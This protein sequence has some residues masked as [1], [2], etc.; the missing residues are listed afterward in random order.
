MKKILS[1]SLAVAIAMTASAQRSWK[2]YIHSEEP[3]VY[4]ISVKEP[5][6]TAKGGELVDAKALAHQRTADAKAAIA[7]HRKANRTGFQSVAEPSLIFTTNYNRVSFA[8]GG[9]VAMRASYSFD[10]AVG[11]IDMV[12]YDV[13]I[14]SSFASRQALGMDATTSRLYLRTIINPKHC[15]HPIVLYFDT[16]FRGG[17][18]GSYTPRLRSGYVSIAGL[19][20]G[21][22]VTTFC[23]LNAAPTT[24]DFQGPNAYNFNFS[25]VIRYE[26]PFLDN[27]MKAGVAAELPAVSGSYGETFMPVPQRVPDFPIYLQYMWGKHRQSHIRASAVLRNM[28]LYNDARQTTTDL[29]GWGVQFSGNIHVNKMLQF[30]MN[31]VYGEGITPYIQDLTGSGLDF[32]PNPMDANRIQTM[33]MWGFQAAAQINILPNLFVSGG[34]SMVQIQHKNGY[35][36]DDQYRRGQYAFG[37]VFYCFTNRFQIAAEYLWAARKNMNGEHNHANRI[38]L[39][40]KYA[41]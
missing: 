3:S 41:F 26:I 23:D 7:D 36:A 39:L 21:R 25:T 9:F 28:Y 8:F 19:T 15:N 14:A 18:E 38:N 27:H 1:L 2:R 10:N 13:P 6:M 12:P 33:P 20:F 32:T 35:F 17:A 30:F 24:I 4:I 34:Y 29:F 5:D 22:D 11:N 37:N 16:D 40:L 31:G